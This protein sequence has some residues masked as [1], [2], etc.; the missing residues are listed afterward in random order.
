MVSFDYFYETWSWWLVF[1][2]T[3]LLLTSLL[4]RRNYNRSKFV[5]IVIL[6]L[7]ISLYIFYPSLISIPDGKN[8][9]N[10]GHVISVPDYERLEKASWKTA[11]RELIS[12][13]LN[14]EH[15]DLYVTN[16]DKINSD[17]IVLFYNITLSNNTSTIMHSGERKKIES[18]LLL[19]E[20]KEILITF[21][22][23]QANTSVFYE[24]AL[25]SNTGI[26]FTYNYKTEVRLNPLDV[27]IQIFLFL[28]AYVGVYLII[29]ETIKEIKNPFWFNLH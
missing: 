21:F 14:L 11:L 5:M 9:D 25:Y 4:K 2:I 15:Y 22:Q 1:V 10:G 28:I 23:I 13:P 18:A 29:L 6:P 17:K 7:I 20:E 16:L 8:A 26:N 19:N 3:L 24:P 27:F 12:R